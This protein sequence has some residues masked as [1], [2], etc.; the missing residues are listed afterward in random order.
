MAK[1]HQASS[2]VC[3]ECSANQP[4]P[5]FEQDMN[6]TIREYAKAY[7]SPVKQFYP[8]MEAQMAVWGTTIY[9]EDLIE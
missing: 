3:S 2:N 8:S 5:W 7:I 1:E 4:A 9:P 6:T